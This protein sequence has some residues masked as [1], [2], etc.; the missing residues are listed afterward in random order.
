MKHADMGGGHSS[1]AQA[2]TV[3]RAGLVSPPQPPGASRRWV[4]LSSQQ[5]GRAQDGWWDGNQLAYLHSH[6]PAPTAHTVAFGKSVVF[7]LGK[8]GSQTRL[9]SNA[10]RE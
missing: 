2:G 8:C 4:R 3:G 7:C 10:E 6:I 9:S 1:W 5:E